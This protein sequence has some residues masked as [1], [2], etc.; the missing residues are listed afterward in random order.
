MRHV[1]VRELKNNPSLALRAARVEPVLVLNR[2]APEALIVSLR[3]AGAP[4][5][6]VRLV[7]ARALQ[8]SGLELGRALRVAGIA[9]PEKSVGGAHPAEL[10]PEP[11]VPAEPARVAEALAPYLAGP[12]PD[13]QGD[14][15]G[16]GWLPAIVGRIVRCIDPVRI[17]LFG[18][19]AR[20]TAHRDSDYDLLVVLAAVSDRRAAGLSIA[21]SLRDL[22]ISKDIVVA[23]PE[24]VAWAPTMT[25][26]VL[27]AAVAEGRTLY[28]RPA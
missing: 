6:G 22:P 28:E 12:G 11:S 16:D 27:R 25:G 13:L 5:P 15:G 2:D 7:V 9:S 21:R 19:R 24:E 23:T 8:Q 14:G 10:G 18:S 1:T 4:D 17:V 20:G 26:D 3:A